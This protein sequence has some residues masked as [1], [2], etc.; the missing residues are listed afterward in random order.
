MTEAAAPNRY[1]DAVHARRRELREQ[2]GLLTGGH[3]AGL[4]DALLL[5]RA[6]AGAEAADA[7]ADLRREI[8]GH[9]RGP[10]G[11]GL[12]AEVA[13]AA[14]AVGDAAHR[15][16][17]GQARGAARRVAADRGLP[18]PPRWPALPPAPPPTAAPPPPHPVGLVDVLADAGAWRLA[19]LPLAVA[20]LTGLAGP[21]V[22][23]PAVGA[24]VLVLWTVVRAR[25]AAA[26][27]ARLRTWCADLLTD[28]RARIDAELARRTTALVINA[29][30]HLDT[31]LARRRAALDAELAVLAPQ[32]PG[33]PA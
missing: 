2:R 33:A 32:A 30:T 8:D 10:A 23:L 14:Q 18:L 16:W 15:R 5:A 22:L 11:T 17:S 26:E 27:R 31:A 21:A 25:R 9:L 1:V 12:H 13:A 28:T 4:R 24:G 19:V 7:L 3:R 20:P 29:G 6:A